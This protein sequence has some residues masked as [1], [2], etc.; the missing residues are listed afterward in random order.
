MIL[1]ETGGLIEAACD[2]YSAVT[3]LED[4]AGLQLDEAGRSIATEER[5][6]DRGRG[7]CRGVDG[8]VSASIVYV[9]QRN[10][11]VRMVERIE[12]LRRSFELSTFPMRD[13]ESLRDI[14]VEIAVIRPIEC[15]A[16][17]LTEVG[18]R[19]EV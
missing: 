13:L 4:E 7:G 11:E 17:L 18:R 15:I 3:G 2:D 5:A 14:Q 8:T 6:Q 9:I 12:E 16:S 1:K 19:S 10:L